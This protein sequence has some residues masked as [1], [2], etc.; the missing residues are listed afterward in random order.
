MF[1]LGLT[2]VF[3]IALVA[4]LVFGPEKFP[5]IAKNFLKFLNELKAS[6]S[7]VQSELYDLEDEVQKEFQNIKKRGGKGLKTT[8]KKQ[9][10]NQRG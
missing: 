5:S 8:R 4:F 7:E 6:F 3:I 10:R 1:G 9:R 2:E